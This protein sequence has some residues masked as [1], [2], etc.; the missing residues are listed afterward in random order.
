M[1]IA[2]GV[3]YLRPMGPHC[4]KDELI[5]IMQ[6]INV[7]VLE[8]QEKNFKVMLLGDF[9]AKIKRTRHGLLG[10]NYAWIVSN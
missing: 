8:L 6:A 4:D 3:V 2:I 5:E 9:N 7:R 10:D 1:D